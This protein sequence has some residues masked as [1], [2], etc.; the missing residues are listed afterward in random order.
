MFIFG[1]FEEQKGK[2]AQ[3]C[4]H[5]AVEYGIIIL[6]IVVGGVHLLVCFAMLNALQRNLPR[7]QKS[8]KKYYEQTE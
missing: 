7:Y 1:I 5:F 4:L 2:F 8:E 6:N 3:T